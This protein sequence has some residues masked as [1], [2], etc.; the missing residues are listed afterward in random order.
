ML[1]STN[2]YI[3]EDNSDVAVV[4]AAAVAD[5]TKAPDIDNCEKLV[6]D[7]L[8]GIICAND[9]NVVQ[10]HSVKL[11]NHSHTSWDE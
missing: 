4:V 9:S 10:V 7:A 1:L 3:I 6:L 2:A 8:Q 5:D 11:F